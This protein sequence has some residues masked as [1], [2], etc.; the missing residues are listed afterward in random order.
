MITDNKNSRRCADAPATLRKVREII[1]KSPFSK[2]YYS[3]D[4][5]LTSILRS[6]PMYTHWEEAD[7]DR[8][9]QNGNHAE[10]VAEI[11][12]VFQRANNQWTHEMQVSFVENVLSGMRTTIFLFGINYNTTDVS[13]CEL[14]DGLQRMTALSLFLDGKLRVF[15]EYS[16]KEYPLA[17]LK[18]NHLN[19]RVYDFA[20]L[21][22]A[23]QFYID[24]NRN[25]THSPTDIEKAEKYI[26]QLNT[27]R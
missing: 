3:V 17:L 25:I 26:R 8:I 21:Q 23:V 1:A 19:V 18:R 15:G 13:T 5:P 7:K 16:V 2:Q 22:E 10:Y 20:T 14:L 6:L 24:M 27:P 11:T 12:P 4:F 9:R